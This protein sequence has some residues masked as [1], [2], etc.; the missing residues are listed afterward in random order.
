[1]VARGVE[2]MGIAIVA[3]GRFCPGPAVG[4]DPIVTVAV[5]ILCPSAEGALADTAGRPAVRRMVESAWAGGATPIVVVAP[6]PDGG[7]AAA[8]AGSPAILAEP[9]PEATGPVGQIARG[10]RVA[11]DSVT[12]TDA[13]LI[14]PGRMVWIDAETVTT[15]IEAHGADRSSLLRPAYEGDPG[16]PVLLPMDLVDQFATQPAELMP[17]E[18]VDGMVAVGAGLAL[19]DL[20][21]PGSTHDLST[22]IDDLPAYQGPAEPGAGPAPE[23]GAAAAESADEGPLEGPSLA[24]Y[25]QATDE[26]AE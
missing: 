11:A 5:V 7:V 15:M 4:Y 24:P 22:S 8:L 18:L 6:D 12:E 2:V 25:A 16:W 26:T 13:A 21:D 19:L 1:M 9:A 10:I 17:D 3:Q 20:G 23:W 14:W